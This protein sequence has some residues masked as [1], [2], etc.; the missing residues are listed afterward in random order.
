MD[1]RQIF[2]KYNFNV[3]QKRVWLIGAHISHWV[4][5]ILVY[6]LPGLVVMMDFWLQVAT[7][8]LR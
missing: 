2:N 3:F 4:I 5:N 6:S 8:Q 1:S 7:I